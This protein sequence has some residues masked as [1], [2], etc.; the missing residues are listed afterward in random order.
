MLRSSI[1]TALILGGGSVAVVVAAALSLLLGSANIP[2]EDVLHSLVAFDATNMNH[3]VI[4]DLRIPRTIGD[5]LVGASLAVAGATMQGMTRNPLADAGI[6]GINAGAA[7]AL[8]LCLALLSSVDYKLVVL[9]SFAGATL[10]VVVV[11][12]L[13][14]FNH[15]KQSPVRLVLAGT[16]VG[17]LLAAVSQ[18]IALRYHVSQELTFWTVGGVAGI[19]SSQLM[20]AAPWILVA[21]VCAVVLSRSL[22]LLGLGEEAARGRGLSVGRT[23]VLCMLVVLVLAGAA[24]SLAGPIAFVGLIVPHMVRGIIGP[25]YRRIIPCSLVV[26]SLFML[27]ADLASR[28]VN[29][30]HETPIGLLFAVIGVPVFLVIARRG[31]RQMNE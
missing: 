3:Q 28:L 7:F 4:A 18:A 16:A 26:G 13:T 12:G 9:C 5:I 27:L 20:D 22:S 31:S 30:P 24:V 10:A 6:L 21:L 11:Y 23:K 2:L 1:K 14:G 29:P 15:G 19:R 25:D 8:A 17:T